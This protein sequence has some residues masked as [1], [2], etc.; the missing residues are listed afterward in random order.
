M[1]AAAPWRRT[2]GADPWTGRRRRG[3]TG[4]PTARRAERTGRPAAPAGPRRLGAPGPGRRSGTPR[5]RRP[6][7]APGHGRV[8]VALAVTGLALGL[9]LAA[10]QQ[11]APAAALPALAADLPGHTGHPGHTS[12][13]VTAYLLTATA[14]LPLHGKLGDLHGRKGMILLALALFTAGTALSG[15]ARS[16]DELVAFRAVQGL[17]AGGLLTGVQALAAEAT[18]ARSRARL[19][20]LIAAVYATGSAAG[21]LLGGHLAAV[22]SWRWSFHLTVPL[23]L[24]ALVLVAAALATR[25]A[26][27]PAARRARPDILGALLLTTAT[28]CT[29]LL[30]AW[31][32][33][34]YAWSSRPVLGLACG[35][36]GTALLHLV[37]AHRAP[38]PV[39][40]LRLLRDPTLLVSGLVA[41]ALGAAL[42]GAAVFL[43]AFFQHAAGPGTGALRT[44]LLLLPFLAALG[45]ACL[46][47]G[48]LVA[49]TGRPSAYAVT[50]GAVAVVAMWLLTQ[51][52]PDTPRLD[53]S[54]WQALLGIGVGLALPA[55]SVAVQQA[56]P[57]ADL[58]AATGAHVLFR[59][60]GACAGA[61]LS[62][63]L[64]TGRHDRSGALREG[65]AA[66][67][68]VYAEAAPRALLHLLPVLVAG[69]LLAFFLKD[70]PPGP[71][72]AQGTVLPARTTGRVPPPGPTPTLAS[73]HVPQARPAPAAAGASEGHTASG[74]T[75]AP[76]T[77]EAPAADAAGPTGRSAAGPGTDTPAGAELVTA[78]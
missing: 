1:G 73:R 52:R 15:W 71:R 19:M 2:R 74:A 67:T 3:T 41:A 47:S 8:R 65:A 66:Y 34:Q 32:G 30:L 27:G 24:T 7:S 53:H 14:S 44:A 70:R 69:L 17:G 31:G 54:V 21:P 46:V 12:W 60:L 68:R 78:P 57:A 63:T 42:T 77:S 26:D 20:G 22:A 28:S 64:V 56:A 23:A 9:L 59:Q 51:L 33:S 11:L 49:R 55:L 40:P 39:V 16:L 5:A 75:P 4:G 37:V 72:G 45:T 43:P 35:A 13:A 62:A 25:P 18:P 48:H 36:V 10:L 29:V 6:R 76:R 61:T 38:E 50:G 58:G